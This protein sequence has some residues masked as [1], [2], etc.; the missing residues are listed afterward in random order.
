MAFS[1]SRLEQ[2]AR[3]VYGDD[4]CT[5][6]KLIGTGL[7]DDLLMARIQKAA[8]IMQLKAEAAAIRRHPEW[9]LEHRNLLHRI[10]HSRRDRRI[11]G[12]TYPLLDRNFPTINP[13]RS[14]RLFAAER[15]C[16]DRLQAIIRGQPAAVGA[17]EMGREARRHVVRGATTC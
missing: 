5:Q 15:A 10:D 12:K 4:P 1:W 7:R 2:L 8:A 13:S 9:N 17:H 11:D 6:F 16:M 14:L 3:D